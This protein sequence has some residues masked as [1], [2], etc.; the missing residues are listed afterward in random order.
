MNIS[1][2]ENTPPHP[3]FAKWD[4][5]H[6]FMFHNCFLQFWLWKLLAWTKLRELIII[7]PS[8]STKWMH[9]KWFKARTYLGSTNCI[10]VLGMIQLDTQKS[11]L[12]IFS[13]AEHWW[14]QQEGIKKKQSE[15]REELCSFGLSP[16]LPLYQLFFQLVEP[17]RHC[18]MLISKRH[19]WSPC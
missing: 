11:T 7:S 10:S 18:L 3:Q 9:Y 8:V 4:V 12:T 6:K 14:L 16:A 15:R 1:V 13:L 17:C 19:F 2:I 5:Y